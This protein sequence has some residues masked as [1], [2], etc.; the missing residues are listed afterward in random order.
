MY[1][2]FCYKLSAENVTKD[3]QILGDI[4][5]GNSE[6]MKYLTLAFSQAGSAGKLMG[7]D[8]LQMVNAGFNPLQVISEKT[9]RSMGDLRKDMEKGKISFSMLNLFM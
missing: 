8:L 1:D 2:I 6:R 9:G 5:G 7:Q 4:S 3:L